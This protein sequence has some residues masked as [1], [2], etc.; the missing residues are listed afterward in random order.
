MGEEVQWPALDWVAG[1]CLPILLEVACMLPPREEALR[2]SL[3]TVRNRTVWQRTVSSEQCR[4]NE[5]LHVPQQ[6]S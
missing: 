4:W 6:H 5:R 1:D 3:C 2:K